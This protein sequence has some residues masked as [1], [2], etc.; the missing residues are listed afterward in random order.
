MSSGTTAVFVALAALVSAAVVDI[1]HRVCAW[2]WPLTA[3]SCV[4]TPGEAVLQAQLNVHEQADFSRLLATG[5]STALVGAAVAA[6]LWVVASLRAS[7]PAASLPVATLL[8][9]PTQLSVTEA[10][11]VVPSELEDLDDSELLS[12]RPAW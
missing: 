4:P 9:A 10:V 3:P 8:A 1:S 5:V 12:Y 2:W 7:A 6:T 11:T